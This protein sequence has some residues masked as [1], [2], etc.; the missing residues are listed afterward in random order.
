MGTT[1]QQPSQICSPDECKQ[2][3]LGCT[4]QRCTNK[5]MLICRYT[6]CGFGH[7]NVPSQ[8]LMLTFVAFRAAGSNA[9]D[10]RKNGS[11]SSDTMTL[12]K[13]GEGTESCSSTTLGVTK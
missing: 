13:E 10:S 4:E 12:R 6:C 3:V 2:R 8:Q 9:E 7:I 11:N 1:L 5:A